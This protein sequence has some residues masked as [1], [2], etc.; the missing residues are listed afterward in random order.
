MKY[1]FETPIQGTIGISHY[2]CNIQWHNG[3]II[4]DEMEK[5]GGLDK[6][7]DP[8]ELLLSSI[9]SCIL[10]TLRMYIDRK[11]WEVERI[12]VFSNMFSETEKGKSKNVIDVDIRFP[13]GIPDERKMRMLEIARNCPI[14]KLIEKALDVRHFVYRD[15]DTKTV[16]YSGNNFKIEWKPG[17][18][19]H[20]TRCWKQ[21]LTVFDPRNQKWINP[22]G[23]D[24]ETIRKQ[25][26]RCPS[27]ALVFVEK[28]SG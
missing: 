21:L 14:S 28:K 9:T 11:D 15:S 26:A 18:C 27:G 3:E 2:M 1:R 19:Q 5:S 10:I 20:S 16:N 24:S 12:S 6:G 4:S 25:V 8:Y 23:S 22:E 13:A 7:P 17:F